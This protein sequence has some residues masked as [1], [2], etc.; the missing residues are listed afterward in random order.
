[1]ISP[2]EEETHH[3]KKGFRGWKRGRNRSK[4]TIRTKEREKTCV[5]KTSTPGEKEGAKLV[6]DFKIGEKRVVGEHLLDVC[7]N[8]QKGGR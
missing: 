6:H 5:A 2:N 8:S 3:V 1:L 4:K 7:T